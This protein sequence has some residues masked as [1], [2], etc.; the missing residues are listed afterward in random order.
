MILRNISS[1][2]FVAAKVLLKFEDGPVSFRIL[3]GATLADVSEKVHNIC[4]W[5]RG[6]AFS[7]DV[8]FTAADG[9]RGRDRS[10]PLIASPVSRL[11]CSRDQLGRTE[12]L[13]AAHRHR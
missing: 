9:S 10:H 4:K 7:I 1:E 2:R 12:G 6:G 8:Q 11:G 13:I 5:H 3:R